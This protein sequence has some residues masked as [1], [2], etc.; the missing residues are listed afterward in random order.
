M[1]Y[2]TRCTR[3]CTPPTCGA[4]QQ[5]G[6]PGSASYTSISPVHC[7]GGRRP[8]RRRTVQ[9]GRHPRSHWRP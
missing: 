8:R 3:T 7:R 5:G 9:W 4:R 6:G 2:T 1:S